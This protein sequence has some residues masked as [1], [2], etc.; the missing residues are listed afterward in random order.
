MENI[1]NNNKF[2]FL[3]QTVTSDSRVL[4]SYVP[5]GLM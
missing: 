2:F 3:Y 5:S 1:L 4:V